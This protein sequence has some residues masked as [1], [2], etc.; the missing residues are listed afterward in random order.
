MLIFP[1]NQESQLA[2][3]AGFRDHV[4]PLLIAYLP[5]GLTVVRDAAGAP[6]FLLLRYRNEAGDVA[7]GL[8]NLRLGFNPL[9]AEQ[10][11]AATAAGQRAVLVGFDEGYFRL[12]LRSTQ[13]EGAADRTGDWH[14][15]VFA[16][17][18][19]TSSAVSLTP[20]ETQIL[21]S[22]LEDDLSVVEVEVDLRYR[23]LV[24]GMPWL[25][26]AQ[27][28]ALKSQLAALL[29]EPASAEQIVMAFQSLP[30]QAEIVS[31]RAL[32]TDAP[33]P[34]RPTL[35]TEVALRSLDLLFT[36]DPASSPMAAPSYRLRP[37]AADDP[38]TYAWDLINYRQEQRHY[39]LAWSVRELAAEIADPQQRQKLF[40]IA[41][42]LDLFGQVDVFAI[43]HM[44]C[45][46]DYLREVRVDLRFIGA[47]GVP[48][49]RNF[50]FDGTADTAR[51]TA[52]YPALT[53]D[54]QL[55]YRIT[56]VLAPP[57]GAGWPITLKREFVTA[58]GPVVEISRATT[59]LDV[60]RVE[61]EPR[62][63]EKAARID[64]DLFPVATPASPLTHI[65]LTPAKLSAWVA[66]AAT[67]AS[68]NLAARVV[69]QAP[70]GVNQPPVT[71]FDGPVAEH[72]IRI[73][74]Y[75]LEVLDPDRVTIVLA[76]EAAEQ[77]AFAA[78]AVAPLA[79]DSKYYTLAPD[80]SKVWNFYR[81]S[82]FEP[83]RF[84]YRIDY[85]AYDEAHHTLPLASTD[86]QIAE[87]PALTVRP[88]VHAQEHT[89]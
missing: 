87:G 61:A 71:L 43:N 15:A 13:I 53:R 65:T 18:A 42:Q 35:L 19:V 9:A 50:R 80:T 26:T 8:L 58:D 59:G 31:W 82:V 36:C 72:E 66:L 48:E 4:D 55:D 75:Q 49:Y 76:P 46:A 89:S 6:D 7:G 47:A 70:S 39:M 20:N 21:Q 23:G 25:V 51:F 28:A 81:S 54:F 52:T 14:R 74:A 77:L 40:P 73:A 11:A 45:D 1:H 38:P 10:I 85:V 88:P 34:D 41:G 32:D 29:P 16:G 24:A 56:T 86:W 37:A 17:G 67:N 44:P 30:Q 83:I 69:A 22:L 78:V 63:F 57:S 64:I 84:R 27:A 60:V 79:G 2:P 12:R 68:G 3:T 5:D 62:V 33:E